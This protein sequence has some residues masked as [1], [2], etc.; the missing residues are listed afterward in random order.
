M[1]IKILFTLLLFAIVNTAS[2]QQAI[3]TSLRS[4]LKPGISKTE[5]EI[6]IKNLCLLGK[7]WGFLKYYHPLIA[8]GKYNWDKELL[9]FLPNYNRV[10]NIKERNDSLEGWV[11]KFGNIEPCNTCNDSLLNNAKLKPDFSWISSNQL[12]GRLVDKLKYIRQN[13]L[14]TDHYYMKFMSQDD[15]FL[16]ISQHENGYSNLNYP[17]DA[18]GVLSV[19]RFWNLIE[20]WYP[21]KY[22]LPVSWDDVLRKYLIEML[23]AKDIDEYTLTVEAMV[24]HIHDSHGFF[25]MGKTAAVQGKYYMPFTAKFLQHKLVVISFLNDTLANAAGIK[26]LD[27]IERIDDVP[28]DTLVRR[29]SNYCPASNQAALLRTLSYWIMRSKNMQSNLTIQRSHTLV[30]TI[31]KNYLPKLLPSPDMNPPFFNLQK[32][33]A[34]CML[35]DSIGYINLGNFDRKDSL[36]LQTFVRGTN[37]LIID[38]RQNQMDFKG[39][40]D[41][42]ADIILPPD[43]YFAKFSTAQPSYPGVFTY[44][45]PINMSNNP[46]RNYYKGKI[47]ILINEQTQSTGEFITMAY[48]KAP[49]AVTIGTATAGADG[50]VSYVTLPGGI[51][52]QYTGLGIYYPDGRETQRIGIKPDIIVNETINGYRNNKDEQLEQAIE[53]LQVNNK[54]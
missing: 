34:F 52:I 27:I 1:K 20:Y 17:S 48:Q 44:S 40:G 6:R 29:L 2:A 43:N 36:A 24:T 11:D 9:Q 47:A 39:G 16:G 42:V 38:N 5:R 41:I 3:D 30:N 21:Y 12:S 8:N 28:V 49:D 25:S 35:K 14:Y 18:Y 23:T 53:Y 33:S 54:R 26:P 4:F 22:N 15:I 46:G 13:R 19:Y 45:R 51:M 32:D 37:K 50:N 31:V 10:K 7:I